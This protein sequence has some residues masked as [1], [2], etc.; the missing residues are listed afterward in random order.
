MDDVKQSLKFK[1]TLWVRGGGAI[2]SQVSDHWVNTKFIPST[3]E[4]PIY[5][6]GI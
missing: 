4:N 5:A 2:P 1:V 6:Y 3:Q